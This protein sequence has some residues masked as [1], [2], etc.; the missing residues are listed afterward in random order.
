MTTRSVCA[1]VLAVLATGCASTVS[2]DIDDSTRFTQLAGSVPLSDDSPLRLRMRWAEVSGEDDQRLDSGQTIRLD[3]TVI[4][5]PALVGIDLDLTYYS[6]AVGGELELQDGLN[7][8]SYY[9]ISQTEFDFT[10]TES[11]NQLSRNDD[12]TE[13][14]FQIGISAGVGNGLDLGLAGAFSLGRDFSGISEIDLTL[15]YELLSSLVLSG[16]YRWFKYNYSTAGA[17][18]DLEVDFT[19]PFIGLYLPF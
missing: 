15:D 17:D 3:D 9:G 1:I 14:Y 16:G 6:I 13:L 4:S 8:I 7:L 5:G 2:I 11:G 10:L 18:S 19:G 12:T